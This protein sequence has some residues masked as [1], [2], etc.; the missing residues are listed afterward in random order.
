MT[1]DDETT[2]FTLHVLI[3]RKRISVRVGY[4]WLLLA[5]LCIWWAC[6]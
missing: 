3:C 1:K 5:G 4:F 2:F 6:R